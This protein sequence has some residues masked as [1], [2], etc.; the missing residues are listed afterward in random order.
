MYCTGLETSDLTE[1]K[2]D[3]SELKIVIFSVLKDS[4]VMEI[5]KN[6]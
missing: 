3:V 5:I 4:G 1:I 6:S 2:I